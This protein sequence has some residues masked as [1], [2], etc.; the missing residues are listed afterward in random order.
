MLTLF[1]I[2]N[3][4]T[5]KSVL[6]QTQENEKTAFFQ[7]NATE[8]INE[9]LNDIWAMIRETAEE[10]CDGDIEDVRREKI[11][12][13]FLKM[14]NMF[15]G[16]ELDRVYTWSR[17]AKPAIH[18]CERPVPELVEYVNAENYIY[19]TRS[20]DNLSRS[21]LKDGDA[22]VIHNM[23]I[24]SEA[25]FMRI[26]ETINP[27]DIPA[28]LALGKTAQRNR[29]YAEAREWFSRITK[30]QETFTGI[31]ALLACYEDETKYF[32]SKC[33][34][35]RHFNRYANGKVKDLNRMQCSVYKKWCAFYE[36]RIEQANDGADQLKK[37]YVSLA[38][39]YARFERNRGNCEKALDI[40]KSI[41]ETYPEIHRVYA[42]EA[43][44]YQFKPYMNCYYDIEKAIATFIKADDAFTSSGENEKYDAKGRKCIL[45]P[46]ANAYFHVGKYE[47]A[48]KVCDVVLSIDRREERAK[49]L[50]KRIYRIAA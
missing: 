39:R 34:D 30:T 43:M 21:A 9:E 20:M 10:C 40:L 8:V 23:E 7:N 4:K 37:E 15:S 33:K 47:E 14:T 24:F 36:E 50:K 44:V 45:M 19:L 46:L 18:C 17:Y 13:S 22:N 27:N 32:L 2:R 38:T 35:G 48:A 3:S 16:E 28:C 31:T 1:D 11:G 5:N 29:E 25:V 49:A 12:A 42:E 26:L 6:P 41:P